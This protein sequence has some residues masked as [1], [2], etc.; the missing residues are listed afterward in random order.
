MKSISETLLDVIFPRT[1]VLCQR[2]ISGPDETPVCLQCR[3]KVKFIND[4][5]FDVNHLESIYSSLSFEGAARE[6]I[7]AFKYQGK[8]Y[9]TP[10]LVDLWMRHWEWDG[11]RVGG[12]IGV[13][14]PYW[15]EWRRGYNQSVL[16]AR[17]LGSRLRL[18]VFTGWLKRPLWSP[19]QTILT[20][21]KR[22][23]NALR[24]FRLGRRIPGRLPKSIL[25]VDDLYT[26]GATLQACAALLKSIGVKQVYASTLA[27]EL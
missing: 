15:R 12:I 24:S 19:S 17:E 26:T 13:P 14:M 3:A 11:S 7:H 5:S 1:C 27:R 6:L 2:D 4:E 9:L 21:E 8:D 18:P 22:Q 10:L 23:R 16:L 25:L 20:R